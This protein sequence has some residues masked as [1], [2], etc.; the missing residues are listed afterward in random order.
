MG[1]LTAESRGNAGSPEILALA[2]LNI[3]TIFQPIMN[4]METGDA[5]S[6]VGES[7]TDPGL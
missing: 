5:A 2:R 1:K 7:G 4:K 6:G 3:E